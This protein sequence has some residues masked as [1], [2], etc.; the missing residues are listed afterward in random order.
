VKAYIP[1]EW[2][3]LSTMRHPKNDMKHLDSVLIELY[4][5]HLPRKNS[6]FDVAPKWT[7]MFQWTSCPL[8]DV[9]TI[10]LIMEPLQPSRSNK[11]GGYKVQVTP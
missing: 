10:I 6:L 7:E 3:F 2:Q 4:Q 8:K 9:R 1:V 5:K 11:S